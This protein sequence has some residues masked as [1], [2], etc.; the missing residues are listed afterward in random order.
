M[1]TK[2]K[3]L[4][5]IIIFAVTAVIIAAA[6]IIV[7]NN[8]NKPSSGN[9]IYY[10]QQ[11]NGKYLQF[12]DDKTFSYIY[13]PA[14][15]MAKKPIATNQVDILGKGTWEQ[16]GNK[17]IIK[18]ED[19]DSTITFAEKDGYLYRED[20]VFRG[21]TSDA[22][23]LNN[24]YLWEESEDKHTAVWFLNDGTMSYDFFWGGDKSS[25]WGTYVRVDN[26]LIARYNDTPDIS[27]RFLVL[28]NG[29]SQDIYSKKEIK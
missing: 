18:Y 2:N 17:I 22:K 15:D 10:S 25:K 28:D 14:K 8:T 7:T 5:T 4:K 23:L 19:S 20:T 24:K 3:I 16:Q 13:D 21:I 11:A 12:F 26:I 1:K 9:G 27:H 29:I 6:V